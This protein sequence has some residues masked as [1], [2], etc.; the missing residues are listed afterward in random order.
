MPAREEEVVSAFREAAQAFRSA[1]A[2]DRA[3]KREFARRVRNAV[4]RVYLA[5]SRLPRGGSVATATRRVRRS[6][7]TTAERW[8]DASAPG[9]GTRRWRRSSPRSTGSSH[10]APPGWK[11]HVTWTRFGRCGSRSSSAGARMPSTCCGRCITSRGRRLNV[12]EP[13]LDRSTTWPY[14]DGEPGAVPLRPERPPDRRR[15][16]AR[17]RRARGRRGAAVRLGD[18]RDDRDRARAALGRATDRARAGRVLR[19]RRPLRASSSA[20][21]SGTSCSTRPARR[22]RRRPRLGRGAVEPA[23]DDA[24]LRG[25]RGAPRRPSS[26]TRPRRR[27]S[28]CARSSTAATSSCTRRR[29]TSPATTTSCSAPSSASGPSTP[30]GCA[31]SAPAPG[32]SRRPTPPGC[33]SAA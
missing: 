13:P 12:M 18:G 14:E 21:G 11:N 3:E 2:N 31:S 29:S 7:G 8:K 30:P 28:T 6:I 26:A 27:P 25:R 22:R 33:S 10:V 1:L 16:R 23:P 19:H 9:S 32:S 15:G 4:A 17:A 5:A 24:R 20:G